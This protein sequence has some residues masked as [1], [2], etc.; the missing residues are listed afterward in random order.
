MAQRHWKCD[1]LPEV[2]GSALHPH[3][4]SGFSCKEAPLKG[5]KMARVKIKR[6]SND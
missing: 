5:F 6:L 2:Y 3:P 4:E 1:N